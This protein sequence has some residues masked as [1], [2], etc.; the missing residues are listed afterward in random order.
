[1]EGI[2]RAR[3]EAVSN[4]VW[5]RVRNSLYKLK[6]FQMPDLRTFSNIL[7]IWQNIYLEKKI[8]QLEH[9]RIVV[10][11]GKSVLQI[12]IYIKVKPKC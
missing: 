12:Y 8:K 7:Y 10:Q 3:A 4:K 5:G 6:V 11:K 9:I 2:V 1:M